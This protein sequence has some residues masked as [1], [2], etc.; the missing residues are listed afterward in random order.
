MRQK[1]NFQGEKSTNPKL[2]SFKVQMKLINSYQDWSKEKKNYHYHE[3]K[4][5]NTARALKRAYDKHLKI[6]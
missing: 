5:D 2:D 4:G 6:F 1:T 3:L